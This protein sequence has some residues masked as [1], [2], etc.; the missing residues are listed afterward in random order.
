M[1]E[2]EEDQWEGGWDVYGIGADDGRMVAITIG[3]I[4]Y[5]D[6]VWVAIGLGSQSPVVLSNATATDAAEAFGW[7]IDERELVA[8]HHRQ[9]ETDDLKVSLDRAIL[10]LGQYRR[11]RSALERHARQHS[12]TGAALHI[13]RDNAP[14]GWNDARDRDV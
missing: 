10:T 7:A 2:H 5:G 6:D 3:V 13:L 9:R 14:P 12:A 11:I 8:D 1:I 4:N